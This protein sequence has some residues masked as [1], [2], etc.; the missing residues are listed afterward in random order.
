MPVPHFFLCV[1]DA[2]IIP[3]SGL[4]EGLSHLTHVKILEQFT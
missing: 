2:Q 3:T 1:R 4:L